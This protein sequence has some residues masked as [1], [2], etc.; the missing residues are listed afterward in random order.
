MV[1]DAETGSRSVG[2]SM[3]LTWRRTQESQECPLE[4]E[5]TIYRPLRASSVE[6]RVMWHDG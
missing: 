2:T 3:M 1:N 6:E 5:M 4:E